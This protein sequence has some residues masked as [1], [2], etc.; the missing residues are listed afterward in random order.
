MTGETSPEQEIKDLTKRVAELTNRSAARLMRFVGSVWLTG[1]LI[2]EMDEVRTFASALLSGYQGLASEGSKE[3]LTI[4]VKDGFGVP[5]CSS[6]TLILM[7]RSTA[8]R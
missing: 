5:T 7:R 3:R 6:Q 4:P 8:M 2:S 1:K